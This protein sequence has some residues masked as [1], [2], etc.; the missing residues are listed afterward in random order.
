MTEVFSNTANIM[1]TA[2]HNNI[3]YFQIIRTQPFKW[4]CDND[5]QFRTS[6]W[7]L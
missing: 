7:Y 2:E 5:G 1:F 4:S 6:V 3:R